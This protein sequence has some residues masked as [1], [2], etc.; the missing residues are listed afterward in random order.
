[1][2]PTP[3]VMSWSGGKDSALALHALQTDPRYEVVSLLTSMSSVYGRVSHHGVREEL[4][5]LQAA[6]IGLPLDKLCL[7]SSAEAP[8]TKEQYFEL[9]GT[10]MRRYPRR[11]RHVRR[12]R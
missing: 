4:M 9:L 5:E 12:A 1:M 2:T 7:P 6:A 8:C 3:V 10:T 11:R